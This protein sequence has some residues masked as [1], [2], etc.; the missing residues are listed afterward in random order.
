MNEGNS[1]AGEA[2]GILRRMAR[3]VL[4]L[5]DARM[6]LFALEFQTERL[7]FLDTLLKFAV[8]IAMAAVALLLG[9][10]TLAFYVWHV[11][12][13]PGLLAM[14]GLFLLAAGFLLWR[15]RSHLRQSPIPFTRT[16]EEFR[17][18]RACLTTR[19]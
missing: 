3:S 5:I 13:F 14:T 8:A 11:S 6:R 18:D 19:D 2:T 15:L 7:R 9:T 16:L 17:K 4:T 10:F 12:G 1:N